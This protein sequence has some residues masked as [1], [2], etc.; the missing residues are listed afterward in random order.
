MPYPCESRPSVW[1][2]STAWAAGK[3]PDIDHTK[4][5]VEIDF[6]A[7]GV[8]RAATFRYQYRLDGADRDWTVPT[9]SRSIVYSNVH[10]GHYRFLVR[11][12]T[13]GGLTGPLAAFSFQV[14]PP[15][16]QTLVV[17]YR[18]RRSAG[19]DRLG[20]SPVS[21]RPVAGDRT[22]AYPHRLRSPRRRGLGA[23]EDRDPERSGQALRTEYFGIHRLGPA[24]PRHP[25]RFWRAL[26]T[27]FGRSM[28]APNIWKI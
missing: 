21:R 6:A 17:S 24:S 7:S 8:F 23:V 3:L 4:N 16:W 11:T 20:R 10:P 28:R 2:V 19:R 27:W 15:F 9:T 22:H 13:A 14:L 5:N 12:V 26:A 1:L 25:A 18:D